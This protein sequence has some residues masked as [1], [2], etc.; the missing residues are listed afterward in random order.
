MKT[1]ITYLLKATGCEGYAQPVLDTYLTRAVATLVFSKVIASQPP[2]SLE[3]I[4]VTTQLVRG[5]A[6]RILY[7]TLDTYKGENIENT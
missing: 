7:K 1:Q 3:L 2:G 5:R 4:E 6:E